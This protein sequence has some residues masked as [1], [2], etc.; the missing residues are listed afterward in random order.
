V[1]REIA[2]ELHDEAGACVSAIASSV[3]TFAAQL[4]DQR[5]ARISDHV[6]E[7][8]KSADR[9]K[10]INRSILKQ[11]RPG[12]IGQVSLAHL[13]E[14]LFVGLQ[15]AHRETKISG[16]VG[17]LS[18]SYGEGCDL[19][20]Y[21]CVQEGITAAVRKGNAKTISVDICEHKTRATRKHSLRTTLRFDGT[22]FSGS[23]PKD[24]TFATIAEA[25]ACAWWRMHYKKR[26]V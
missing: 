16:T 9:L 26:C 3:R 18:K 23:K 13:I 12:P 19:T 5:S 7:I 6:G 14:E 24:P 20:L 22:G 8:L 4:E 25:R 2:H 1:R 15:R 10:E 21:R 17:S 11:L